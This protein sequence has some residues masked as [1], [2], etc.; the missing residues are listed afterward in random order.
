MTAGKGQE[1]ENKG[2]IGE[3]AYALLCYYGNKLSGMFC[4]CSLFKDHNHSSVT[5]AEFVI[6]VP[7]TLQVISSCHL[8]A[9]DLVAKVS[10]GIK[11]SNL[12]RTRLYPNVAHCSALTLRYSRRNPIS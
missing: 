4:C 2:H 8:Q 9:I 7:F 11:A 6:T 5:F 12:P 1:S 3:V 10:T